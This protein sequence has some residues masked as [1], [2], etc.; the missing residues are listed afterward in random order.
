LMRK[1]VTLLYEKEDFG[2]AI[3][4]ADYG[5]TYINAF[6]GYQI[7]FE[8][9]KEK[10][11]SNKLEVL[12]LQWLIVSDIE[13][14]NF[15][16]QPDKVKEEFRKLRSEVEV[17]VENV[18]V[19]LAEDIGN[20]SYE[21]TKDVGTRLGYKVLDM[22]IPRIIRKYFSPGTLSQAAV[23]EQYVEKLPY[24]SNRC[25]AG[26]EIYNQMKQRNQ[27]ESLRRLC[28]GCKFEKQIIANHITKT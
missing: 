20:E 22:F 11:E 13:Q 18:I 2:K 15:E 27:L 5:Y 19:S 9:M 4:R 3:K 21:R 8:Q 25:I 6:A 16:R 28:I 1:T 17:P 24:L 14:V 26:E 12:L 23:L 7:V 10:G